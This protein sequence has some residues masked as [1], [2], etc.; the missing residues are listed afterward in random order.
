MHFLDSIVDSVNGL[1]WGPLMLV[2]ILG[3]GLFLM[4]RLRFMPLAKIAAGFR[5]AWGNRAKGDADTGEISRS[6][7]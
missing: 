1:V 4:L 2:L 7:R 3:T 5:L 6:R